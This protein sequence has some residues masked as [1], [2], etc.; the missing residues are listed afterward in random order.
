MKN[1]LYD[2]LAD[3]KCKVCSIDGQPFLHFGS[4]EQLRD[5]TLKISDKSQQYL[6][7]NS[8][9]SPETRIGNNT[10]LDNVCLPGKA[11]IGTGC[12]ISDIRFDLPVTI[13][14]NS[15]VCGFKLSDGSFVTVITD[16]KENPK[17]LIDS[18]EL[19]NMPRFYKGKNFDES[20]TKFNQSADEEKVSL[21]FWK[22]G[23]VV[24][25]K[26]LFAFIADQFLAGAVETHEAQF[27]GV[28]DK[29]HVRD[30]LDDRV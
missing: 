13:A 2:G 3:C 23:I 20:L 24:F 21:A 18:T 30:I 5:N 14:D 7:I 22:K 8:F 6:K 9:V 12:L 16:I 19:W 4:S 11:D 15:S 1:I 28:L 10:V 25:P 27:F 26:E 29:D 17:S